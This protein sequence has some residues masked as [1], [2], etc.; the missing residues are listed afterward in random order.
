MIQTAQY[1]LAHNENIYYSILNKVLILAILLFLQF[2]LVKKERIKTNLFCKK[3]VEGASI[4][5]KGI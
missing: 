5:W 2:F 3:Q 1:L 4:C